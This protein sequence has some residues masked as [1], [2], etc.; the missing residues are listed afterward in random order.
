[1][2]SEHADEVLAIFRA[3]IEGGNATFETAVPSW[4]GFSAGKLP[5][6]RF[7]ARDAG[8]VLGWVALS[9][10]STRAVYR[11]VVELSVYVHPGA[12]G[13]GVGRALLGAVI[14]SSER[15][16]LWTLRAGIFPENTASLRLHEAFGFRRVGVHE[17]VGRHDF[18]GQ[19][20]WRDV[21]LLE[22]RSAVV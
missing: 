10:T 14:D 3:G 16:G 20:R 12:Q 13:R 18:G 19:S 9:P 7:V 2:L 17:R 6:H 21:V 1:M 22:R 8:R 5:G 4:A 15:A 11:G